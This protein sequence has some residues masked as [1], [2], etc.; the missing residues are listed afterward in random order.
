MLVSAQNS[1]QARN[2]AF[3]ANLTEVSENIS[4][5][6]YQVDKYL[7]SNLIKQKSIAS[8][9]RHKLKSLQY[10]IA[11]QIRLIDSVYVSPPTGQYKQSSDFK[12]AQ[13]KSSDDIVS[14]TS[15]V[16]M[17]LREM[18]NEL[19]QLRQKD[20]ALAEIRLKQSVEQMEE[21]QARE[22]K[23][24]QNKAAKRQKTNDEQKIGKTQREL[25]MHEQTSR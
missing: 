16:K 23:K 18:N 5:I 13:S 20:S 22:R 9:V 15:H 19:E 7:R 1:K 2:N 4:A 24:R 14:L 10:S 25:D 11:F 12:M 6:E 8:D 3:F 17:Q 21:F